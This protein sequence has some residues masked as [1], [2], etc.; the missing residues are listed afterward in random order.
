MAEHHQDQEMVPDPVAAFFARDEEPVDI[1]LTKVVPA[2]NMGICRAIVGTLNTSPL[3]HQS[4]TLRKSLCRLAQP[5]AT[6]D[7]RHL[8]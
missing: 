2:A 1:W 3:G 4:V 8:L 5:R 7:T 6:F